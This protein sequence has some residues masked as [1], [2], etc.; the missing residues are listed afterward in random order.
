MIQTDND[1]ILFVFNKFFISFIKD[2]KDCASHSIKQ[3]IK[4]KFKVVDKMSNEYLINLWDEC[5]PQF[6]KFTTLT[7]TDLSLDSDIMSLKLIADVSLSDIKTSFHNDDI[8]WNHVIILLIFAFMFYE[9]DEDDV[10]DAESR[11]Q[12]EILLKKVVDTLSMIQKGNSNIDMEEIL[13]DD[14]KALLS[15]VKFIVT[16]SEDTKENTGDYKEDP[17]KPDF[18]I[19]DIFGDIA[20]DSKIANLAR[21]I[22]EEIDISSL[23]IEKPEDIMKLM[24]FSGSNNVMGDI[25]KKV[26]SKISSKIESG[27]LGQDEIIGEA[28]TMMSML[29]KSGAGG[30]L[31]NILNNPLMNQFMKSMK[32]GKPMQTK[33]DVI[34]KAS[35][36]ERLKKKLE[37]KRAVSN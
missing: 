16:P 4:K 18:N 27:D 36:R 12:D 7:T 14:I 28:M 29:G 10:I 26:S 13:D 23:N 35:T 17:K 37:E 15:K 22:S 25:I 1:K 9:E 21:E 30:P 34:N 19:S 2:V 3:I 31:G 33:T 24:D 8:F 11:A 32:K 6:H 20:K 5:E